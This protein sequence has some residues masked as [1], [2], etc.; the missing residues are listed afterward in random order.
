[1]QQTTSATQ[2]AWTG[3]KLLFGQA[4]YYHFG[5]PAVQAVRVA[6]YPKQEE[7]EK[8]MTFGLHLSKAR[9]KGKK[10]NEMPHPGI[11]LTDLGSI[12]S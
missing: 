9:K 12:Q 11:D 7:K 6:V 5:L 1:L 3:G 8:N 10:K 2:P 4:T